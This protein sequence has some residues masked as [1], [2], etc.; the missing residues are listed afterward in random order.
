MSNY[1]V[2]CVELFGIKLVSKCW[3]MLFPNMDAIMHTF[4]C[5][6]LSI[7]YFYW[8]P[9]VWITVGSCACHVWCSCP[10][11][12]DCL[13]QLIFDWLMSGQLN[14]KP[15]C[16]IIL[17]FTGWVTIRSILDWYTLVTQVHKHCSYRI[18][19]C[20][21][22]FVGFYKFS[23]KTLSLPYCL[24]LLTHHCDNNVEVVR[25]SSRQAIND[26]FDTMFFFFLFWLACTGWT[27]ILLP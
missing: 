16:H 25:L 15:Y 24:F 19:A 14:C 22:Q 5:P 20:M 2:L 23:S 11:T 27:T 3:F 12:G 4:L 1:T 21:Y 9:S 6:F 26:L 8:H 18:F 7:A 10:C 13:T 17:I